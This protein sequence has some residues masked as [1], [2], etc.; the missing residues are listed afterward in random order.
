M[1]RL[2][3]LYAYV[4]R[5]SEAVDGLV[6]LVR[7]EPQLSWLCLEYAPS[8]FPCIRRGHYVGGTSAPRT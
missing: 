8:P 3:L 4:T 7:R 5:A 1:S 6:T 2:G